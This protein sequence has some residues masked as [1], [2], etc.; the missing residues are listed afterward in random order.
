L[1]LC[2]YDLLS[3]PLPFPGKLKLELLE[4]TRCPENISLKLIDHGL[5]P[6]LPLLSPGPL[7]PEPPIRQL[8]AQ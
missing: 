1:L 6:R 3:F 4:W 2:T 7:G 5:K 8:Q